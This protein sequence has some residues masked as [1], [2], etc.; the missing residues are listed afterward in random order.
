L[1]VSREIA[2]ED[3]FA[4]IALLDRY[5]EAIDTRRW[6]ILD[7]IFTDDLEWTWPDGT[8]TVGRAAVVEAIRGHLDGSGPSHNLFGTYRVELDGDVAEAKAHRRSYFGP[9]APSELFMESLGDYR[10]RLVRGDGV[11]RITHFEESVFIRRG[12]RDVFQV[13]PG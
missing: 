9:A 3:R 7:E 5:A 8:T 11:W 10:V 6:E 12:S 4:V 1:S 2:H 13:R